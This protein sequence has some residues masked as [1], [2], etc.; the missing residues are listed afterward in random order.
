MIFTKP[1]SLTI[2][3]F[4]Y[5]LFGEFYQYIAMIAPNL[6]FKKSVNLASVSYLKSYALC[7]NFLHLGRLT[8]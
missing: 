7:I 6:F 3:I 8:A 5:S 2:L 1:I 4:F